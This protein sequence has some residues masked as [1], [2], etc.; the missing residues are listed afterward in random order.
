MSLIFTQGKKKT[1]PTNLK[2][3]REAE[4]VPRRGLTYMEDSV[5][6]TGFE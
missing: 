2:E 4:K 5:Q 3:Q 6:K 1:K